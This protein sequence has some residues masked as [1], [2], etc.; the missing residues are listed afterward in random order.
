[1][2]TMRATGSFAR[3]SES[4]AGVGLSPH[5]AGAARCHLEY[6]TKLPSVPVAKSGMR[7]RPRL[8]IVLSVKIQGP[9]MI[10]TG[11]RGMESRTAA[12]GEA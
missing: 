2:T 7:F 5:S 9:P 3:N 6:D 4:V 1:M 8:R 10:K 11:T 12:S